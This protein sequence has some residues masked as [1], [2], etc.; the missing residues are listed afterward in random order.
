MR[1]F[2]NDDK[3][4]GLAFLETGVS[5]TSV[6]VVKNFILLS[7]FVQS[8]CF[9]A[10]SEDPFRLVL[11]G[12]DK[13]P[14]HIAT[15]DFLIYGEELA[16]LT[17]DIHG[18]QRLYEAE[19]GDTGALDSG[20]LICTSEMHCA[21]QALCSLPIKR[22][23]TIPASELLFG[24]IDGSIQRTVGVAKSVYKRLHL[25][26]NLLMRHVQ[27]SAALNPKSFRHVRNDYAI[28]SLPPLLDSYLLSVYQNLSTNRQFELTRQIASNPIEIKYD[29]DR[30]KW[31]T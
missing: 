23:T 30:L 21:S 19:L 27:H 11:L 29:L 9:A 15:A 3:L 18:E 7:D 12:H 17:T 8:V 14:L 26:S 13:R 25:L 6:R 31:L 4:I 16:F 24:H 28:K 2:E 20:Q 22:G 10:F 5:V 1:A